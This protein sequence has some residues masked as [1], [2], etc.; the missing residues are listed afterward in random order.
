MLR[1]VDILSRFPIVI[2][3][4]RF[5]KIKKKRGRRRGD[6]K[7]TQLLVLQTEKMR[8]PPAAI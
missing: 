4:G 2:I 5:G 8:L 6:R 3:R 7:I 1:K